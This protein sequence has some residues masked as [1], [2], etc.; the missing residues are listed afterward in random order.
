MAFTSGVYNPLGRL[1]TYKGIYCKLMDIT[2]P[3][4]WMKFVI[5]QNGY[6][7]NAITHQ[8]NTSY[9]WYHAKLKKIEIWAYDKAAILDAE[10][11]LNE[12]MA[13]ICVQMLTNNGMWK[14]GKPLKNKVRWAD[15]EDD[16]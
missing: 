11:R 3:A 10:H 15:V 16:N 1:H 9:I 13:H 4:D 5:G 7:F 8:S 14:D 2:I 6:Y 12:R